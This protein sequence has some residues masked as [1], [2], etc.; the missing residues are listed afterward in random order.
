MKRMGL[1]ICHCGTNIADTVD[2]EALAKRFESYPGIEISTTYKYMCSHP[3]QEMIKESIEKYNLDG[4]IVAACSPTL[5]EVTFRRVT[6]ASGVNPYQCE[7]ANIREQCSWVHT[8]NVKATEKAERIIKSIIEKVRLNEDLDPIKVDVTRKALV[9][10]GGIAGIQ[11]ALDI[12]DAGY[13]LILVE[14]EPSIGGH[15]A[16]LSET[17]P[18]LDCS[19]C[20]LTPK[21]VEIASHPNIELLTYSEVKKVDGYV[22]NFKVL[23]E[24]KPKGVDWDLCTGCGECSDVCPISVPSEFERGLGERTAIYTPFPQAVPNKPVID[25]DNCL[26]FK[27][28]ACGL[29]SQQCDAD[30]VTYNDD[31]NYREEDIGAIVVATG[32]ELYPILNI[33]EYGAGEIDDVID[34]LAFE[35]LLSAS[36]PTGGEIR[37]PSD[38]KIV[39][40]VVFIQCAGSRDPEKHK[41][42]CSR[43]CCMYSTKQAM[44]FKHSV[45]HGQPY[46]FYIDIRSGGK[47]YEEFVERAQREDGVIYIRGKVSK[48][49]R[50]GDK[51]KIIG[52]DTISNKPVEIEADLVVLAMAMVPTPGTD[53]LANTLKVGT[54]ANGFLQETHPKLRPLESIT[55]GFF[56]AGCAQAPKDIPDAVSQA[57]GAASKVVG[58]FSG[59][60]L[61]LEP[62]IATVDEEKCS[63]CRICISVCPYNARVF[64]EVKGIARVNEALCESCGACVVACPSGATNQRNLT[65]EQISIMAKAILSVEEEE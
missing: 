20:I 1:F 10:G 16:Q 61:Q 3:G 25:T 51:V 34:G 65:D 43:I 23:I 44:L 47:G 24:E 59:E 33:G 21:M 7:M 58:L 31:P 8:D 52:V 32:Y 5:H 27:T 36:G 53:K 22:G 56:F 55:S 46:I 38:G 17:F 42:Y 49:Y 2:V 18:T 29:C 63:G 28:G 41:P 50:D 40:D 11:A 48:L 15:M 60:Y 14:K 57:S 9:I 54:G 39:E 35:R 4:V 64:D 13:P 19:Q 30:A 26:K 62:T 12:A 6:R 37:R 45:H